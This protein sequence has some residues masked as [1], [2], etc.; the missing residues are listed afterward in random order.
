MLYRL[1]TAI[2]SSSYFT[3][4]QSAYFRPNL[5]LVISALEKGRVSVISHIHI[6]ETSLSGLE[7]LEYALAIEYHSDTKD[8]ARCR[9]WNERKD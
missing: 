7:I 8:V 2:P 5:H 3:L 9:V 6:L 1:K 4:E